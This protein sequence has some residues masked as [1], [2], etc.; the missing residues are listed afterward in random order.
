VTIRQWSLRSGAGTLGL[1]ALGACAGLGG[2]GGVGGGMGSP[3]YQSDQVSG[4][5]LGVD[6]RARQIGLQLRDGQTVMLDYDGQTQVVYLN[7]SYAVT[8]LERGDQVTARI[9]AFGNAYYT[10][11]V[12]VD[13]SVS[14]AGGGWGSVQA[15]QGTVRQV[16]RS[17]G[18]FTLDVNNRVRVLVSLPPTLRRSDVYTFQRLRPGD[19]VRLY[20]VFVANS[21]VELQRFY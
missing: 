1:V 6:P 11:L 18:L 20:G 8:A 13:Q 10:D 21:R 3:Q 15:L 9:Q 7:R 4:I 14:S 16:D 2:L 17:N 5:V 12:R 19:F